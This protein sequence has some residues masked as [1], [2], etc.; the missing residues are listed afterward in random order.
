MDIPEWIDLQEQV[1]THIKKHDLFNWDEALTEEEM[2]YL[3]NLL[4]TF[5]PIFYPGS[6]GFKETVEPYLKEK[7]K[8]IEGLRNVISKMSA[9]RVDDGRIIQRQEKEIDELKKEV[10]DLKRQLEKYE[11]SKYDKDDFDGKRD[12]WDDLGKWA[13]ENTF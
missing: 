11:T 10:A 4:L 2:S 13:S 6:V 12:P 3:E 1:R 8:E 7:S 5:A 9:D